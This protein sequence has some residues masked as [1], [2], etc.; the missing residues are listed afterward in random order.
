MN[1]K[2]LI[3]LSKYNEKK[4]CNVFILHELQL[5]SV[6]QKFYLK[7]L[8]IPVRIITICQYNVYFIKIF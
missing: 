5:I 4:G 3:S 6:M 7:I 1:I 8:L 2:T